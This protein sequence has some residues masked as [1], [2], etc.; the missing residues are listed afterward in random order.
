MNC[1]ECKKL[2]KDFIN[3]SLD[4]KTTLEFVE[5]VKSCPECMEELSIDF[6]VSEGLKRLDNVTSFN[7]QEELEEKIESSTSK[8]KFQI[9]FVV[10]AVVVT[11]IAAFL[12]GVFLST[13]F[14]Y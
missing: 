2:I 11:V 7:L 6:L 5:H 12:L 10:V 13:M 4:N 14:I 9:Q 3:D 1:I 8:A